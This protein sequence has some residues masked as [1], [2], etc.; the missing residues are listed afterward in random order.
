MK[1]MKQSKNPKSIVPK[2]RS[3]SHKGENGR[4]LVIG[5]SKDYIGA[6]ALAG[7]AAL[8]SGCDIVKIATPEKV[9]W[10]INALSPDLITVKLKGDYLRSAHLKELLSLRKDFDVVL[11]GSG[12]SQIDKKFLNDLLKR[13]SKLQVPLVIDADAVKIAEIKNIENTI[14]T[15]HGKEFELFLQTNKKTRLI[16]ELKN[17]KRSD[18]EKM[19]LIQ[20]NLADFFL[21]NNILLLKGKRDLEIGRASCRER[22]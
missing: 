11:I 13:L 9:A 3:N 2:R 14:I 18:K 19:K 12:A 4:V 16:N 15:P 5:G 22:V 6:P 8:R 10:A 17:K 21:N 1:K 20:Q 7:L